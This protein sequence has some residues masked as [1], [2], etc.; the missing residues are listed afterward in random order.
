MA[1]VTIPAVTVP[2]RSLSRDQGTVLII[3]ADEGV[4]QSFRNLLQPE[5]VSVRLS[6]SGQEALSM[7]KQKA[8]ALLIVDAALPDRDGIAVLEDAQRSDSRIIGVVMTGTASVE[9]AVRAMKAGSVDFV[10]KPLQPDAVL[11]TVRRLL[12]LYRLRTDHTV[13]KHAAV[14]SGAVRLQSVP[15]QTFRDDGTSRTDDG[16]TEY[17]RGLA[18]GR[19]QSDAQRQ[20]DLALL[21]E[22]VRK[23]DAARSVLQQTVDDEIIE[24][25]LQ[26][27]AKILHESAESRREQIVSQVK[28]A[29][30]AVQESDAVVI[31]VHP[32]DAAVLEAVRSELTERQ[33]STLKLTIE[34]VTSL[35]RG[36]C[37]LHTTTR[38][39]DASLD[40]QLL[41]LGDALKNRVQ[42]AA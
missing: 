12:E 3:D 24:L 39:V 35:Q 23:F 41:R 27:V 31:Q 40:T 9:L 2:G 7:I 33:N 11:A 10:T 1:E 42:H 36:S 20:Q 19:R 30:G 17:E 15:F 38:L 21:T 28:A 14:R 25:A 4:R 13:L 37:L 32:A 6:G 16:A 18:D 26:I 34:P 22:A 8:P 5:G 29:L